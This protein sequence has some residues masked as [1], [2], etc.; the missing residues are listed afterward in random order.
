LRALTTHIF[1]GVLGITIGTVASGMVNGLNASSDSAV[2]TDSII[3]TNVQRTATHKHAINSVEVSDNIASRLTDKY[4]P[5]AELDTVPNLN[6]S[7]FQAPSPEKNEILPHESLLIALDGL[8]FDMINGGI[9]DP[10][11]TNNAGLALA[12]WF[13]NSS[14]PAREILEFFISDVNESSKLALEYLVATGEYDGLT[15]NILNE[16]ISASEA[17]HEGLIRMIEM[18]SINSSAERNMMLSILPSLTNDSLVGSS[19]LAVQPQLLPAQE[20][21]QFLSDI[22]SYVNSESEEVK[23]AAMVVLGNFSGKDYSYLFEDA[24]ATGTDHLK[25]IAMHAASTGG[26]QTDTIKNQMS[27]IMQDETASLT[28]RADAFNGLHSFNLNEHE[29]NL[30]YQFYQENILPLE[31]EANSG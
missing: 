11:M 21:S 3:K 20:R 18:T 30:I 26:I 15:E 28:L 1:V 25:S 8:S 29:Y 17:E 6:E 27:T 2:D 16:M 24:L 7:V 9:T 13:E 4:D 12:H 31:Q 14:N 10:A 5:V 22:S 19:L 23:S